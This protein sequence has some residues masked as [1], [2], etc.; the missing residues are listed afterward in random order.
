MSEDYQTAPWARDLASHWFAGRLEH[1]HAYFLQNLSGLAPVHS[2]IPPTTSTT[3]NESAQSS[4]KAGDTSHTVSTPSDALVGNDSGVQ[5]NLSRL[6]ADQDFATL[7]N[8][9]ITHFLCTG[10]SLLSQKWPDILSMRTSCT[11][12]SLSS[13]LLKSALGTH[14]MT[15]AS[16]KPSLLAQLLHFR[17]PAGSKLDPHHYPRHSIDASLAALGPVNPIAWYNLVIMQTVRGH[18]RTALQTCDELLD[19]LFPGLVELNHPL[20]IKIGLLFL[21]LI[22]KLNYATHPKLNTL[23]TDV[24]KVVTHRLSSHGAG[25]Q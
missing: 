16:A 14:A 18:T 13:G 6:I 8:A 10:T 22:V 2:L 1:C 11:I 7:H 15:P 23:L 24:E 25:T 5:Q 9:L 21:Y 20:A 19:H 3:A 17:P 12:E 4:I